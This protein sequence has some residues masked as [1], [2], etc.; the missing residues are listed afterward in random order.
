MRVLNLL[1]LNLKESK[2]MKIFNY[3]IPELGKIYDCFDD[4]KISPSRHYKVEIKKII[5]L[6]KLQK[7]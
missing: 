5:P 4:G 1:I 2:I 3:P 6:K 7:N